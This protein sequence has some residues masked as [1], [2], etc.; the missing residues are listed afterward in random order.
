VNRPN[1]TVSNFGEIG[2]TG[3]AK[4][5]VVGARAGAFGRHIHVDFLQEAALEAPRLSTIGDHANKESLF[6]R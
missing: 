4:H 1:G 3:T 6:V 5:Q 2:G